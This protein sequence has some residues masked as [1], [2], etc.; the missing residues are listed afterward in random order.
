M[1]SDWRPGQFN[2]AVG[3]RIEIAF[4]DGRRFLL[5]PEGGRTF[6]IGLDISAAVRAETGDHYYLRGELTAT[7]PAVA[8]AQENIGLRV[9][10]N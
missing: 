3:G 1:S 6:P 5:A 10:I 8:G 9:A 7:L 2:E 4:T